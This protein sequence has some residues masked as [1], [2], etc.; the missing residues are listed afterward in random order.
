[1]IVS[2][3]PFMGVFI[4][5]IL[6]LSGIQAQQAGTDCNGNSYYCLDP[7]NYQ[8]CADLPDGGSETTDTTVYP[9]APD[10]FC[11]NSGRAE[12]DSSARP[13]E[14][15]SSDE[16]P[17]DESSTA[18]SSSTNPDSTVDSE[19]S[20]FSCS[21]AGRFPDSGDCRS[22]YT[23]LQLP[24]GLSQ[25]HSSCL[26][27]MA[28]DPI[29]QRCSSNQSPCQTDFSCSTVGVF[30]DPQDRT[31]YYRCQRNGS[32]Y[33]SFH[34]KCGIGQRFNVRQGRCSLLGLREGGMEDEVQS[35]MKDL[36]RVPG[37]GG[38]N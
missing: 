20:T 10:S 17:S 18:A 32:G 35:P 28:F 1:M 16:S 37:R 30:P 29:T 38:Y 5:A 4:L 33:E 9:C 36:M 25:L 26:F 13:E 3:N 6:A 15:A 31:S 7:E 22:Y 8:L 14:A 19:S 21:T 2:T 11:D 12:C 23:C 34:M 27:G 24:L